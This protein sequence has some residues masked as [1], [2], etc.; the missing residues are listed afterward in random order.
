MTD[1]EW[2]HYGPCGFKPDG[3]I[4]DDNPWL[5]DQDRVNEW[6]RDYAK[7]TWPVD[8]RGLADPIEKMEAI[9]ISAGACFNG[10]VAHH[11]AVAKAVVPDIENWMLDSG[12]SNHLVQDSPDLRR[13]GRVRKL[14]VP[15]TMHTANG[16]VI[17]DEVVSLVVPQLGIT[18]LAHVLENT[19]NVLSLGKLA[20]HHGIRFIW[21][22]GQD[23]PRLTDDKGKITPTWCENYVPFIEAGSAVACTATEAEEVD[24]EIGEQR[25]AESNAAVENQGTVVD[26]R[27]EPC[28]AES[29]AT[30]ELCAP[31]PEVPEAEVEGPEHMEAWPD[32]WDEE[33][34]DGPPIP[35]ESL[36]AQAGGI[37]HQ[38]THKPFSP[39]CEVCNLGKRGRE[40]HSR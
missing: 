26:V 34:M 1:V 27:T 33:D 5:F 24:V 3:T 28:T 23:A 35:V 39:Y 40:R 20:V 29:S 37:D 30:V 32:A 11:G 19:P 31:A 15:L 14:T 17:V 38:M 4:K 13:G 36:R 8:L 16:Q 6:M 7:A 2:Q 18:V 25:V 22:Q 9:N 12:S 21:G 10:T